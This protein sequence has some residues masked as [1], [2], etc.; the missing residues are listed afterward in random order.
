M[1]A[2][3][4]GDYELNLDLIN[5]NVDFP[6]AFALSYAMEDGLQKFYVALENEEQREE[7]KGLYKRL[8]GFEDLHKERLLKEYGSIIGGDID[9]AQFLEANQDVIEGGDIV[10]DTP[11]SIAGKMKNLVD[12]LDL[13]MAIEAQSLDL[14]TRL[15][16]RSDVE[17]VKELFLGLADEEKQH[18]EYISAEMDKYL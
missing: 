7:L 2:E 6:D 3:A 9:P 1:G 16:G 17:A 8:A 10:K 15:A 14:Y 18:L 13:G 5:P 12:I 11:V 4:V